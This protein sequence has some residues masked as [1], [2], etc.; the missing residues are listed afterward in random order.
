MRPAILVCGQGGDAETT[1][2]W[3]GQCARDARY[4]RTASDRFAE[5]VRLAYLEACHSL[6][7]RSGEPP[8]MRITL[9]SDRMS[10]RFSVV[11]ANRSISHRTPR[12]LRA[13]DILQAR[14]ARR[15]QRAAAPVE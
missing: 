10:P 1:A 12:A 7:G 4:S 2:V 14:E 9:E 3:A 13:L 6:I 11:D 5:R 8:L 15:A